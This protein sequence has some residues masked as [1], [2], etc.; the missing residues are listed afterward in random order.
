MRLRLITS[1]PD[2]EPLIA[3]AILTTTGSKPSKAYEALK[4]QPGRAERI[5]ERL[6]FHHGSIF[7]HNRLCWL[8]EADEAE[9][10]ELL[11][12]SHFF[13]I[14]R[15][16]EGGWLMSANLRTVIEYTRRHDDSIAEALLESIK[17]VAPTVYRRLKEASK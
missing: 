17:D 12:K 7:E 14:S 15:L 8:L 4:R 13:Q 16:G 10:L 1:T 2:I 5:I 11:L 6:E 3:T 9:V